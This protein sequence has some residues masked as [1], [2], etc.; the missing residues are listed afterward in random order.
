MKLSELNCAKIIFA[1]DGAY[2]D[3]KRFWQGCPSVMHTKKGY[4]YAAWYSG[5]TREPSQFNYN[6]LVRSCDQGKTW[7][8][9]L[10]IIDSLPDLSIRAIDIQLWLDPTDKAWVFWV[11]R[12]DEVPDDDH[13]HLS[14]WAITSD[15][16][17]DELPTWSEPRR[18]SEGFLRCQPTVL[19]D[20]RYLLF[21]Y[22][23]TSDKYL[24]SESADGGATWTRKAAGKK[25]ST[26][27]DE[28]MALERQDGSIWL[29]AR[30]NSGTLGESCSYDGGQSWSDGIPGSITA[31]SSRFFLKRL[32]SGLV[33]LIVNNSP[34]ERTNLTAFLSNDDGRTWPWSLLID[35][36]SPVSYPDLVEDKDGWLYLIHDK[37][38][39]TFKEILLSR[40]KET[41]VISGKLCENNSYV[42]KIISKAPDLPYD[43][44][45]FEKQE[46]AEKEK[47]KL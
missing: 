33:L 19:N 15:N 23:W 37:G 40:F 27:F 31:P 14:V 34:D 24:Y 8:K 29:L 38:R 25:L 1:P 47:F 2:A 10:L 3:A 12:Y 30:S 20:G 13:R 43:R 21:A 32:N 39:M 35:K 22:D 17:D 36:S 11:Q 26:P 4:L 45:V 28:T 5:G 46:K 18:I 44:A 9:P 7:S 41:D 16:I 42:C 6:L